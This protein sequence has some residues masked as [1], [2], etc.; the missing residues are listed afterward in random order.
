MPNK[1]LLTFE[2]LTAFHEC[3]AID[4]RIRILNIIQNYQP[5]CSRDLES[6]TGFTQSFCT[7]HLN[8]LKKRELITYKKSYNYHFFSVNDKF[9]DL[10]ISSL[11]T[12]T[13][14]SELGKDLKKWHNLNNKGKLIN[15]RPL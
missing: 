4:S 2:E 3:M 12:T 7:R 6:T 5:I 10:L 15:T 14:A 8:Y 11:I 9:K 13:E 1:R